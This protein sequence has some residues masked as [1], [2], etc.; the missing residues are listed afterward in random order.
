[1]VPVLPAGFCVKGEVSGLP[2]FTV[3]APAL[4]GA[5][6]A[7]LAATPL[8]RSFEVR[9]INPRHIKSARTLAIY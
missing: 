5:R 4:A 2:I 6:R 7:A 9:L 1:V 8:S 3:A